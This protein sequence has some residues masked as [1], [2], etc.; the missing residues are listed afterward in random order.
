[1][2]QE[3]VE[4]QAVGASYASLANDLYAKKDVTAMLACGVTG[5]DHHRREAERLAASDAE[6]SRAHRLA[7]KNLAYNVAANCWPGWGD[8]GVLIDAAHIED[9]LALAQASLD[10]VRELDLGDVPLGTAHW[11]IGALD[12]AAGRAQAAL[13]SF[14][15][16]R[17]SY[18]AAREPVKVLLVDGYLALARSMSEDGTL[19]EAPLDEAIAHLQREGSKEARGFAAQLRTAARI[20]RERRV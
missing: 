7:A 14:A 12:L 10:D 17:A 8:E 4:S 18:L 5:V 13:T 15:R 20:L 19:D 6:R 16:S 11:L 1:V 3:E 2:A 9:G